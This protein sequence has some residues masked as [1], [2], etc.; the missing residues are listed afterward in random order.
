[1]GDWLRRAVL[2]IHW[3]RKRIEDL[4]AQVKRLKERDA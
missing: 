2:C 1:L 4:Q 3:Q